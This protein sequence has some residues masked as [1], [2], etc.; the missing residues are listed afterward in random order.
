MSSPCGIDCADCMPLGGII[1]IGGTLEFEAAIPF[2]AMPGIM[3]PGPNTCVFAS[4]WNG[5]PSI[6]ISGP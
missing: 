4:I 5:L 2:G 1:T 6:V 3:V